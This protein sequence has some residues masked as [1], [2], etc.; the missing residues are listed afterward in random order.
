MKSFQNFAYNIVEEP[1]KAFGTPSRFDAQG[2]PMYTKRPGPKEPGRRAQVQKSPKTVTQVKGEIEAAKRFAGARSG[3]LETRNVPSFVT[4]RRQERASKLLGP[5]PWDMPGGAGA[6]QKTFDRGMRKLVPPTGPSKGHRERAL[7]DFINQS[8]KEFGTSTDEII[9]NMMKGKSA[10]P[11]ASPVAAT[12]DPWKPSETATK[13]KPV[14]QSQVSQK[15]AEYRAAQKPPSPPKTELGGTKK[16]VSFSTPTRSKSPSSSRTSVLDVKA[17]EVK[18]TKVVEPKAK[19]L[20]GLKLGTEPAGPLVSNRPG[21]SKTIR[22][23]KGPGRTGVLGKPKAGQMVGAKI[24]PVKVADVTPKTP[25]ITGQGV[26]K[27]K[28][29]SIPAPPK[30][31]VQA[32]TNLKPAPVKVQKSTALKIPSPAAPK[33]KPLSATK[34]TQSQRL[35]DTVIKASKQIRSDIAAERASERAKMMKGLGTAGKVLGAVQTGIEAKK[36]YDIAKAMGS[37]ERRSIGAG[38]AR[39]IGSGLGG[40][41][42][43]TLGSVAGP[44]GSAVGATAGITIGSQLGSRAYDVITGD[45][46]KKVTTQGVLTNIR[47]AVPQE[48]RAQVPANVR[49]GFTDFVKSAGKTYGDWQRSQQKEEYQLDEFNIKTISGKFAKSAGAEIGGEVI[50]KASGNNPIVRKA[51]DIATS[52]VGLG[53]VAGPAAVG[54]TLGTEVLAPAAVKL[55][56]Q[57]RQAQQARLNQLVPSGRTDVSGK[58]AQIR[59]LNR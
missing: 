13:P 10:T 12:P 45:P 46:K 49:K 1:R 7:R 34:T 55:A 32:K 35:A 38:A 30:P 40:V 51:V 31:V 6:G 57:R 56:Q 37:S 21:E 52:G 8:S 29:L 11:F 15:A 18:G 19:T 47:K 24:E 50:K 26:V 43:G 41:V 53:R 36:G 48:I 3:G 27:T 54:Y 58:P 2:E 59:P 20:P 9:A 39:A 22:P 44:I 33:I 28:P 23:Q 42:G 4:Q 16:A 5:N 25:K 14:K 17:T